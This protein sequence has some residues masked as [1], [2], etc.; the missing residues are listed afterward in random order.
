MA[1]PK[2]M[3]NFEVRTLPDG[4]YRARYDIVDAAGIVI[5]SGEAGKGQESSALALSQARSR[6]IAAIDALVRRPI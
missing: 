2:F 6:A 3:A 5:E 1:R 4:T